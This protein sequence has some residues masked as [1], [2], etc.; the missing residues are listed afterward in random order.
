MVSIR[1]VQSQLKQIGY[2]FRGWGRGEVK[3]LSRILANDEIIK[4]CANGYYM[5]GFAMLVATDH[6]LILV[7]RKPM[8]LNMEAIWYDKIG[9]IDYC[10]RLFNATIT[11]SSPNKDLNFTSLNHDRL[12]Q[13]LAFSQQKMIAAKQGDAPE[14]GERR[15]ED[16]MMQVENS[17]QDTSWNIL[18]TR[19]EVSKP[20]EDMGWHQLEGQANDEN[21]TIDPVWE[22]A[23]EPQVPLTQPTAKFKQYTESHLPFSRRRY[24][25]AENQQSL[26]ENPTV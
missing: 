14:E 25:S 20:E 3:E 17:R 19:T 11:I 18:P 24:F 7:D 6:R 9:Q 5:G 21:Q 1:E 8:F 23:K 2:N 22:I 12:R 26:P 13:I 10:H 15:A 4:Q 16:S